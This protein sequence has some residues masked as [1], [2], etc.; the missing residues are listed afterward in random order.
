MPTEKQEHLRVLAPEMLSLLKRL[1]SDYHWGRLVVCDNDDHSP[2]GA[3]ANIRELSQL[4]SPE[5]DSL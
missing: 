3:N 1:H 4:P 2:Y 5:G